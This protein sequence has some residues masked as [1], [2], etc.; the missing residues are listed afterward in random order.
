MCLSHK[1]TCM[2]LVPQSHSFLVVYIV[3]TWTRGAQSTLAHLPQT[4]VPQ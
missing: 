1:A 4:R 2:F 3:T